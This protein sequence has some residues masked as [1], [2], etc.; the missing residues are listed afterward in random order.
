MRKHSQKGA[1]IKGALV[2]IALVC[3]GIVTLSYLFGTVVPPGHVGVR[4]TNFGPLQGLSDRGLAPGYHWSVPFYSRIYLVP[5]KIEVLHF[6]RDQS[7]HPGTLGALEIQTTDGST[8]DVDISVLRRFYSEPGEEN[9]LKHGGP[10]DLLKN[11]GIQMDRW[12]NHL[13]RVLDDELRRGLGTLSTAEFYDPDK[14]EGEVEKAFVNI[15]QR[16]AEFGIRIDALLLR[17]YT[18]RAERI[19]NAIFQ[20]NLQAQEERLNAAASKLAEA[21]AKLEQVSAEWDAKIQTLRV[22]GQNQSVVVRSEGNLY[23]N[24]KIALGDLEVARAKAEVDR[25]KAG[26]LAQSVG[27]KIYVAREAAPLLQSLRGG[28]VT[29][30]DPYSLHGWMDKLGFNSK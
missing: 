1:A 29:D 5:N 24:E 30:V 22:E 25:L 8:V 17:R 3:L 4:Q 11:I 16:V 9:G 7:R 10:A 12:N 23:E 14:R 19:D 20:K 13:K 27:A 15:N 18:Y 6:D 28:V 21:R 2:S 26:A